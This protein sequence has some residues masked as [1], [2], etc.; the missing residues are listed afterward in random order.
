MRDLQFPHSAVIQGKF[1]FTA[2]LLL[3]VLAYYATGKLGLVIPYVGSSITLVWLPTGIA[4]AAL[5]RWGHF[6]LICL[7]VHPGCS[8]AGSQS[9][10]R[11]GPC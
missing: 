7:S 2:H 4:I 1:Q 10:T 8:L 6:W 5:L 3:V 9:V 11:W